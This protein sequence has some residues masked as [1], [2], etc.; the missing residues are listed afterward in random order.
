M[1]GQAEVGSRKLVFLFPG[2]FT[3]YADLWEGKNFP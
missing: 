1:M 2:V 3:T